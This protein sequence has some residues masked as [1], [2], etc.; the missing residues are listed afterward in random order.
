MAS[1]S[2][3]E[4]YE[5]EIEILTYL[6]QSPDAQ[7][8]LEGIIQWWLLERYI[9][10]KT[11]LVRQALSELVNKDLIVEIYHS[12]TTPRYQINRNNMQA[13][14]EVVRGDISQKG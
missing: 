5:I 13:I 1:R 10:H 6:L 7:D 12:S 3:S 9:R 14:Q 4:Q 11:I 2:H 8:T